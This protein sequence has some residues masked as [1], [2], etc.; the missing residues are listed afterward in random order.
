M[1]TSQI[2]L[3]ATLINGAIGFALG[4]IPLLFGYF[5]SRLRTGIIGIIAAT[6]GGMILG[7]FLSVPATVIFTWL[8]VR[9]TKTQDP[10]QTP[11]V[12]QDV[13]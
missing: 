12:H 2:I 1:T 8:A 7:I 5:N 6:V 9:K 11:D 13:D 3:Y 10:G 4:L